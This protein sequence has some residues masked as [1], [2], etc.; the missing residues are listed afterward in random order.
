MTNGLSK[1][2]LIGFDVARIVAIIYIVGVYH[3]LGYVG[4]YYNNSCVL[5]L[6]TL[7]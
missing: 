3:N 7:R 6:Y 5:S 2:R 4:S 1:E